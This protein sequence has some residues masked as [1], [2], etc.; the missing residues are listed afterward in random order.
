MVARAV[1]A[2]V[3]AAN[4]VRAAEDAIDEGMPT[5]AALK[6][7]AEA[8]AEEFKA[9]EENVSTKIERMRREVEEAKSQGERTTE[10]SK[11]DRKRTEPKDAFDGKNHIGWEW[12]LNNHMEVCYGEEGM[13]LMRWIKERAQGEERITHEE[14]RKELKEWLGM[15]RELWTQV[16][17]SEGE[18]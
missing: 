18:K 16:M 3:V 11:K 15:D 17:R 5:K 2:E 13:K 7:M 1:D 10:D 9:Q 8:I 4:L 12:R 6:M 14:G